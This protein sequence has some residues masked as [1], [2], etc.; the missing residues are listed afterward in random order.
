LLP[1]LITDSHFFTK[2]WFWSCGKMRSVDC[3]RWKSKIPQK[4]R[5]GEI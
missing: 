3:D 1:S 4:H 2:L 5:S